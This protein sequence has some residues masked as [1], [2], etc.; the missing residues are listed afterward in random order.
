MEPLIKLSELQEL[1]AVTIAELRH[2]ITGKVDEHFKL[3]AQIIRDLNR[4]GVNAWRDPAAY[5]KLRAKYRA[6]WTSKK[7][8]AILDHMKGKWCNEKII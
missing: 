3:Q 8:L 5:D 6:R 2:F 4:L 7:K 1:D